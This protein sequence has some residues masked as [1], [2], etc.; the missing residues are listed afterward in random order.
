MLDYRLQPYTQEESALDLAGTIR[1]IRRHASEYGIDEKDIAVMGFSAGGIL[2]GEM[3]L[4][5]GGG[6]TPDSLD[7]SYVPDA[8]AWLQ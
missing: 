3:I 1:F 6:I 4:N 2:A 5:Y 8:S 7:P